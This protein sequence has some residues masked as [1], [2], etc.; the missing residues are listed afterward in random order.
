MTF[1]SAPGHEGQNPIPYS[2]PHMPP[3]NT[4]GKRPKSRRRIIAGVSAGL[5]VAFAA[6][7]TG[8]YLIGKSQGGTSNTTGILSPLASPAATSTTKVPSRNIITN[9]DFRIDVTVSKKKCF[10]SAG[11][12]V[13]YAID[14]VFL[15][16]AKDLEGRK[17]K[18]VYEVLGGED[19]EVGNFSLN[20]DNLRYTESSSISTSSSEAT[21]TAQVISVSETS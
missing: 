15:G 2:Q 19:A 10:G 14:P 16:L 13:T 17:F 8:G 4:P 12:N 6:V 5:L 7:G 3:V 11:C 18:V 9:D 1:H 20:G 21:L